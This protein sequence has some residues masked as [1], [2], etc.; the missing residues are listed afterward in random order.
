MARGKAAINSK[1]PMLLVTNAKSSHRVVVRAGL[2]H[3][4]VPGERVA[5]RVI[6]ITQR[7]GEHG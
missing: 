4:V 6:V 3:V 1:N 7:G 5:Q 2:S